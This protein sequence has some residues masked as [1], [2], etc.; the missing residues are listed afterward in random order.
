V[1]SRETN[2]AT[3]REW[4]ELGFFYDRDDQAKK[5]RIVGSASG[6]KKFSGLLR[7][8][9]AEPRHAQVSEH[10]HFGPYM[11][12]KIRTGTE[13]QLDSNAISGRIQDLAKLA[14]LVDARVAASRQGERLVVGPEYAATSEY[15]LEIEI[16]EEGFDPSA[17]DL[18]CQ[19]PG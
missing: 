17:A 11:Y 19:D 9:V 14:D 3:R 6:V 13:P 1:P 12:L 5:W 18:E 10:D 15:I 7:R 16:R 4:R 2:A 8:Y